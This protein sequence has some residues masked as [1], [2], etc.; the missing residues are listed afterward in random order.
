MYLCLEKYSFKVSYIYINSLIQRFII[1]YIF[2]SYL[3]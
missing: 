1:I 2:A 3:F